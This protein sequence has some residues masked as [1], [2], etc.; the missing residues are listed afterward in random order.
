[1]SKRIVCWVGDAPNHRALVSKIAMRFDVAGIIVDR[2]KQLQ[3]KSG[4]SFVLKKLIQKIK[5]GKIDA[6]WTKLQSHYRRNFPQWPNR[7][8]YFTNSV[9]THGAYT[10]TQQL[11]PD[12]IVVSGTSLVKEPMVSF[13][14]PGGIMN[15]HT[16]LSPYVKGGPNCTNW[17]I[18]NNQWS[19]IGNT[20]MWLSAGI[21]SGNII[22][23]EQTVISKEDNLFAIH[24]KVM[25]HAHDLYLR[26]I[27]YVLKANPPC[28]SVHQSTLGKGNLY[29]TKMW[30][31]DKKKQML[32]NLK[33]QRNDIYADAVKT[34]PLPV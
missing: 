5:F 24:L 12:V 4:L 28:Q 1:M 8:V 19:L 10:F 13:P 26:A 3:N 29:L 25:E 11:Q 16:G 34:I 18:A 2:K 9:N 15:L 6:A 31:G 32:R 30:T 7:P 17:C 21:D 20:I 14:A 27:D 33:K 23:S 22:T